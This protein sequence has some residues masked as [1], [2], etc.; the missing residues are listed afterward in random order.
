MVNK[1][2]L[3]NEIPKQDSQILIKE[4]GNNKLF[5]CNFWDL[6]FGYLVCEDAIHTQKDIKLEDIEWWCYTNELL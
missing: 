5:I 6:D 4:I 1:K 3:K 2:T